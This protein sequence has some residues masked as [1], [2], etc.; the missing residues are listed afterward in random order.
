MNYTYPISHQKYFS[1]NFSRKYIFILDLLNFLKA[2]ISRFSNADVIY[3]FDFLINKFRWLWL[4]IC[5]ICLRLLRLHLKKRN[6]NYFT[7]IPYS[8]FQRRNLIK[9]IQLILFEKCESGLLRMATSKNGSLRIF[10]DDTF[11]KWTI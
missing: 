10:R 3:Y 4:I 6:E 11:P 9:I 7:F 1:K 8:I 5:I 2:L